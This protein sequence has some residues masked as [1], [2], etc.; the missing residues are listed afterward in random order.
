[1]RAAVQTEKHRSSGWVDPRYVLPL[2]RQWEETE[3][4]L[5]HNSR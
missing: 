4:L 2:E 1:M 5:C 3:P